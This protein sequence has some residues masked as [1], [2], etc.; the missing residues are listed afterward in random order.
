MVVV[1]LLLLLLLLLLVLSLLLLVLLL[2]VVLFAVCRCVVVKRIKDL[3][4]K[5]GSGGV[6]PVATK[7]ST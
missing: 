1:L 3:K 7:V 2:L 6:D 5:T 4:H